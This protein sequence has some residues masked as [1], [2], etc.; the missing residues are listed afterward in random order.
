MITSKL[1]AKPRLHYDRTLGLASME[2]RGFSNPV[3]LAISNTGHIYVLSRTN[4]TQ[5][6]GIRVGICDL[7]GNY[8]GDF[9]AYGSAP[10]EFIWPTSLAFDSQN[11]LYLADEYNQRIT[12]YD[13]DGKYL[14]HWGIPGKKDGEFNGPS[15]L[16]FDTQDDLYI[17]D[18]RNHRIQKFTSDGRFLL[19]WGEYG[20][21]K[22]QLNLPWGITIAKDRTVYV[23]D[24][25]NN[26]IQQFSGNGDFISSLSGKTGSTKSQFNRPASVAV[27]SEDYA[28]VADW[29]NERV[30][31]I[32]PDRH[33]VQSLRGQADLSKWAEEFY[34]ANPD[35]RLARDTANLTP[36]LTA[37]VTTPYEESARTE[38]Y[39]WGP[40]SVKLDD[41][42]RLY[43]TE[44]LRHR[45]QVF[46]IK[47]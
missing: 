41:K 37:D 47:H 9:G 42:G 17:T 33:I 21:G 43:V 36:T 16:A 3:D 29:G 6:Y 35:E 39:F 4:P 46:T 27:D 1:I 5:T 44:S 20:H 34:E 7:E 10:G 14:T 13:T 25:R 15:A 19:N 24:W 11:R 40:C 18:H 31:V 23:A 8:F 45:V 12:I 38:K 32:N 28:Y 30:Q 26:R 2:G 22:G